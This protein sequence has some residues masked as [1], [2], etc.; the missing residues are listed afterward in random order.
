MAPARFPRAVW[1]FELW[2]PQ[3]RALVLWER[4]SRPSGGVAEWRTHP[5]SSRKGRN[6]KELSLSG[7]SANPGPTVADWR[8]TPAPW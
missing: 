5:E 2:K 1:F 8:T 4:P 7:L 6:R 3:G